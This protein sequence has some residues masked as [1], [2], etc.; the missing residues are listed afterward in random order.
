VEGNRN[1]SLAGE[2]Q[3]HRRRLRGGHCR[4]HIVLAEH[5]LDGDHVGAEFVNQS[6]EPGFDRRKSEFNS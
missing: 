4:P 5:P 1:S 2:Q 3:T 6:G